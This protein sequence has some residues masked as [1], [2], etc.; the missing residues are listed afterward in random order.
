MIGPHIGQATPPD[1]PDLL[2]YELRA[3][4]NVHAD[5]MAMTASELHGELN[6][7]SESDAESA[8]LWLWCRSHADGIAEATKL[9]A[10]WIERAVN[11]SWEAEAQCMMD[12]RAEGSDEWRISDYEDRRLHGE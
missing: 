3:R 7:F 9:L 6:D 2:D 8:Q 12:R 10:P 11:A 1:A 4:R 5:L